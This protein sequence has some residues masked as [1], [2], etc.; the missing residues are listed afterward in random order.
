MPK[1]PGREPTFQTYELS[2]LLVGYWLG[3]LGYDHTYRCCACGN[4]FPSD[5]P[6]GPYG[7]MSWGARVVL[8]SAS[9][10][11]DPVGDICPDCD[12]KLTAL[13]SDKTDGS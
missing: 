6:G 3:P 8:A 1:L 10:A 2:D 13:Y 9:P 7:A 5:A 11:D 4:T 12:T